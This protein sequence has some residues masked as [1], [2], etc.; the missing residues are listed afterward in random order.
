MSSMVEGIL[1]CSHCLTHG[2]DTI[3]VV[4]PHVVHYEH[5]FVYSTGKEL[6]KG[7]YEVSTKM[8]LNKSMILFLEECKDINLKFICL[9]DQEPEE[10]RIILKKG[11]ELE[12]SKQ[13]KGK[14]IRQEAGKVYFDADQLNEYQH[15]N[16]AGASVMH[17]KSSTCYL[18]PKSKKNKS[19][20]QVLRQIWIGNLK[21]IEGSSKR[22]ELFNRADNLR[23]QLNINPNYR[24]KKVEPSEFR[25]DKNKALQE[26]KKII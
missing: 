21:R 13:Y 3:G 2:L 7:L 16:Y 22:E 19:C 26:L 9:L 10:I 11:K 12:K 17:Q 24:A 20:H 5:T 8:F 23:T 4:E 18:N 14:N 1:P 25:N 6:F 15:N